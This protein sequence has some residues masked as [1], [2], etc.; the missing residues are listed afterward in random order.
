MME[1]RAAAG[2]AER[3]GSGPG[4]IMKRSP[5]ELAFEEFLSIETEPTP[6]PTP[7]PTL[8]DH[9][10]NNNINNNIIN[11][12]QHQHLHHHFFQDDHDQHLSFAFKNH[13]D[14]E[15]MMA[16]GTI[17][18]NTGTGG[19]SVATGNLQK[20]WP[21]SQN[22]NS[23]KR[24]TIATTTTI[25]S[26]SSICGSVTGNWSAT[27]P[28]SGDK[29]NT[30]DCKAR[31]ASS[32]SSADHSDEEDL[33]IEAGP[34]EQS[35][36]H[37]IDLK[38]I[39][40]MVSNRDSARRSRKRKQAHMQEL[41]LQVE[42]LKGENA[43]LYK[44]FADAAQQFKE[45]NTNYRVLKSDVEA[46]RAK[47]RLAE[48]VVSVGSLTCGLNQ[49]LQSHLSPVLQPINSIIASHNNNIRHHQLANVSP[50]L[51]V[52]GNGSSFSAIS[53]ISGHGSPLGVGHANP[54]I[55]NANNTAVND[56]VSCV[57]SDIWP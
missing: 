23:S 22:P 11:T 26:Q 6:T 30:K 28:T 37:P 45:A 9:N 54:D 20:Q 16:K 46:L 56:A 43:T 32:G 18:S 41:E 21:Q 52:P 55:H 24:F 8:D 13:L 2:V 40:R 19:V 5:S 10:I 7:N 29:T 4:E 15:D 17:P 3:S 36:D 48:D 12:H 57:S 27:T 42:R 49:L 25:D 44:Q 1:G 51:T 14:D 39:R 35:T 50:T 47:V 34:C 53:S 31:L 33:E 38:R